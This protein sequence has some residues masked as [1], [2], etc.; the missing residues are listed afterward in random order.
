MALTTS[1]V[2]ILPSS[3]IFSSHPE[4]ALTV[5]VYTFAAGDLSICTSLSFVL[6]FFLSNSDSKGI[7]YV[8]E[9]YK[10]ILARLEEVDSVQR[11]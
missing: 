9:A 8:V 1:S 10:L 11:R 7:F 5:H 4:I 6:F 2:S 3:K